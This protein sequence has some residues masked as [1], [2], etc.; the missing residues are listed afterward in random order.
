[1]AIVRV[2]QLYPLA[3]DELSGA[4]EGFADGTPLYWVQEEPWNMGAWPYLKLRFADGLAERWPL[5]EICR[6]ES[7][8]PATGSAASHKL[9]Q[10]ELIERAFAD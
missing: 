10:K 1:V 9:E 6:E 3:F 2:E 5:R 8:S 4:L 7:A